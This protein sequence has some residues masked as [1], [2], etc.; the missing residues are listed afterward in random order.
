[1]D[2]FVSLHLTDPQAARLRDICAEDT[3]H[4][5][6]VFSGDA[7]ME[8]SFA[9]CEVVFGNV[10]ARW[11]PQSEALRWVQLESVGFGEYR[12]LD[13]ATLGQRIT[14]TNL[15][16]FFA[17]PVAESALAGILA[18]LRGVDRFVRLQAA[19][20]W[21][22]G[23]LRAELGTLAGATVVLFG[24]GAINQRLAELL[25][26]FGCTLTPFGRGWTPDRLDEALSSADVVVSTVPETD[27]TMGVFDA[28]RLS[29]LKPSAL[30]VNL[31][32]GSV[33]DE[34]ALAERLRSGRLGGAV[35]DV[36]VREPLP[37]EHP[38]WTCPNTILTQ[39]TGGGTGDE[40]DRK[41][42]HFA[43]NLARYR[44]GEP[45]VGVADF[46]KGY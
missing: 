39:H 44:A 7:A 21:V 12:G 45:P 11:L 28:A 6:G 19:N 26:P 35:L 8:P 9:R 17:E 15:A 33:V 20:E 25:E 22:G 30:F 14:M 10:P 34:D 43:D 3:L 40:I 23:P 18:L 38:F 46:E 27:D 1:M 41:I 37:A 36:T 31:G 4:V 24:F 29:L 32:R 16:G 2:I 5:H 42:D 13:W